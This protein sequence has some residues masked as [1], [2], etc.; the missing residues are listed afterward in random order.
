MV[1]AG[2]IYNTDN[3]LQLLNEIRFPNSSEPIGADHFIQNWLRHVEDF[4]GIHDRRVCI[5]GLC[6]LL[7]CRIV[8]RMRHIKSVVI[9]LLK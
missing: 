6:A 7:Q 4:T 5:M 3:V 1:I 2:I 8:V 9:P